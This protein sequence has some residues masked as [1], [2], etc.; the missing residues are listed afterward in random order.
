SHTVRVTRPG[1]TETTRKFSY[2][3]QSSVAITLSKGALVSLGPEGANPDAAN[4]IFY[5]SSTSY[6]CKEHTKVS[7]PVYMTN[8]TRFREDVEKII[9]NTYLD[10][11]DVTSP[12]GY[13]PGD[14][15]DAFNFYYYYD[16][17]APADA[18]SGC[19]GSVPE[20]YWE[21]VPS[22]DVTVI[23]YPQYYG[24]YADSTCQPTGCYQDYGPGRKLMKAPADKLALFRH[25]TGHAVF[26]LIDTYC[27]T[28]YYYQNNP[29]PNVWTSPES[30]RADAQSSG[31][32]PAQCRQIQKKSSAQSSSSC[33]Q[34]Y[35]QW[36]PMPDIMANGYGGRF[37]D[38][39]TQRINYVLSQAGA[40]N[41]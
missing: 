16:P 15:R 33:I 25:E 22:S 34:N 3:S 7:T 38:A 30:C 40:G 13:L 14:Y 4:I 29:Y 18:F 39:A 32:D 31:R 35:W 23:V 2:P 26:E 37:G 36:D 17:S 10:L 27:G 6:N 1:Y 24:I 12:S 28:T 21:N 9:S 8:E 41:S 20:S 11:E 5:P 19:A